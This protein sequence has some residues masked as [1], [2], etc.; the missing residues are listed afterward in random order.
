VFIVFNF[1]LEVVGSLSTE[2]V[3]DEIF[4]IYPLETT[5]GYIFHTLWLNA[6]LFAL[7]APRLLG[8]PVNK[9]LNEVTLNLLWLCLVVSHFQ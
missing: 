2:K 7:S 5:H 6:K 4:F 3:V 1:I 8:I 9:H